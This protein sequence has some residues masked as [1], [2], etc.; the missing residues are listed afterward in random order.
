[1]AGRAARVRSRRGGQTAH[2]AG[3]GG[4]N[5][6]SRLGWE[7]GRD[8]PGGDTMP[9]AVVRSGTRRWR[10]GLAHATRRGRGPQGRSGGQDI[11]APARHASHLWAGLCLQGGGDAGPRS[12]VAPGGAWWSAP[13]RSRPATSSTRSRRSARSS[14]RSWCRS[15]PRS[16]GAVKEVRFHDGDRVTPETVLLRIDPER[17]RLEAERA[18]AAHRKAVADWKRAEADLQRR[19]ALANESSSPPRS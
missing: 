11:T 10:H 18:E 4:T 19:E 15:P 9:G 1:M 3:R 6:R 14:R 2:G 8:H 13:R 16:S 5:W 17:Y 12:P 7:G